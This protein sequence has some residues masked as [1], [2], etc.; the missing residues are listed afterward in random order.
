MH[1]SRRKRRKARLEL[2]V[3]VGEEGHGVDQGEVDEVEAEALHGDFSSQNFR[4][5]VLAR[6]WDKV[7]EKMWIEKVAVMQ[8]HIYAYHFHCS[9]GVSFFAKYPTCRFLLNSKARP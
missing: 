2:G 4:S 3:V 7:Q 1:P 8:L 6:R 5:W 9:H